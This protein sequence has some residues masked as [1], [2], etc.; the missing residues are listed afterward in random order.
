MANVEA[1]VT[2]SFAW[3]FA[4]LDWPLR[5]PLHRFP[6]LDTRAPDDAR[7]MLVGRF[8]AR[9]F[10]L[11]GEPPG[12]RLALEQPSRRPPRPDLRQLHGGEPGGFSRGR[13]VQ[14]A[15]CP[16]RRRR[17]PSRPGALPGQPQ[18]D[19]RDPGRRA[20]NARQRGRDRRAHLADRRAG[21]ALQ[22]RRDDR[23]AGGR[24]DRIRDP[25]ARSR[26][27]SR[28]ACGA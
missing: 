2:L 17:G 1:V 9:G 3:S 13:S 21:P 15:I 14:A 7:D 18:R 11:H 28:R 26:I 10:D 12:F 5:A 24:S 6:L 8:G 16:A 20:G 22:A 25:D 27:P 19:R 23:D 4:L